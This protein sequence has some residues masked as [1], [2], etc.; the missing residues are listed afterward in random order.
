[1]A[2]EH[3]LPGETRQQFLKRVNAGKFGPPLPPKPEVVPPRGMAA[4]PKASDNLTRSD[5]YKG[6]SSSGSMLKP[7]E[8]KPIVNMRV[9][10]GQSE[11]FTRANQGD[12]AATSKDLQGYAY[13]L[14]KKGKSFEEAKKLMSGLSDFRGLSQGGRD[15]VMNKLDLW[16]AGQIK[17]ND[18][19]QGS[20]RRAA[21]R[22]VLP[23]DNLQMRQSNSQQ[24]LANTANRVGVLD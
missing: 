4:A 17:L 19:K 13:D 20:I 22:Q 16:K 11:G 6:A 1:M 7:E 2:E 9:G 24:N 15:Y 5:I 18:N 10:M 3:F 8:K 23:S 12:L 14:M 21:Q